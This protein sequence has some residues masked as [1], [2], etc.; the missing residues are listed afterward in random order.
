MAPDIFSQLKPVGAT[1][2]L[3]ELRPLF[4]FFAYV[5]I[6]GSRKRQLSLPCCSLACK[7]IEPRREHPRP[8]AHNEGRHQWKGGSG[9]LS[10]DGE[11][12]AEGR[13]E[14]TV[15]NRFSLDETLDVGEDT[16]TPITGDYKFPFKFTGGIESV[17]VELL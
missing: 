9:V 1:T 16:G 8:K 17:T 10:V 14:K 12:M 6:L 2:T 15:P 4:L 5:S 7:L 11:R 13:I 3:L